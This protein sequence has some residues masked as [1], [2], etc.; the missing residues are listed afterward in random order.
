MHTRAGPAALSLSFIW[1]VARLLVIRRGA[2]GQGSA[3]GTAG[4]LALAAGEAGREARRADGARVMLWMANEVRTVVERKARLYMC[5]YRRRT[6]P[7]P[8]PDGCGWPVPEGNGRP[9]PLPLPAWL[10]VGV[11]SS[12]WRLPKAAPVGCGGLAVP[13]GK[14]L[15]KPL[16]RP[17]G[18]GPL[19]LPEGKPLGK[20]R[21]KMA[22]QFSIYFPRVGPV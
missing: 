4:A 17:V 12:S 9:V 10:L 21:K 18:R 3:R 1:I 8:E 5:C 7:L 20:P 6:L 13:E 2:G 15:G 16:G 22:S 19:P 11:G 14:P